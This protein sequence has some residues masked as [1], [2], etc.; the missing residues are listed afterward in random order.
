[1]FLL[2]AF[3]FMCLF[4]PLTSNTFALTGAFNSQSL[5]P[6]VL[7]NYSANSQSSNTYQQQQAQ[8]SYPPNYGAYSAA[9][10]HLISQPAHSS[11]PM[12]HPPLPSYPPL[13][14]TNNPHAPPPL[15]NYQSF[16]Q[17]APLPPLPPPPP[18]Y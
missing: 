1:M 8:M 2:P 6:P 10:Q 5:M 12:Y 14:T 7:Q 9:T 13:P 16:P 15:P 3:L 11:Y 4:S 17:T 18:P